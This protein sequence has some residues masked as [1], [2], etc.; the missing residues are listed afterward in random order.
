MSFFTKYFESYK[1]VMKGIGDSTHSP[2]LR[3]IGKFLTTLKL[4]FDM[5]PFIVIIFGG[6]AFLFGWRP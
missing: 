4:L 6:I 5:L 3:G 2:I 1:S